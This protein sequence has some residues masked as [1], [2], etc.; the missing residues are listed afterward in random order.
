M[1]SAEAFSGIALL[2]L[3]ACGDPLP[4]EAQWLAGTW[5]WE[6]SCCTI[7][8]TGPVADA[9]NQF[10]MH[11]HHNGDVE[12]VE[13]GVQTQRTR[14]EVGIVVADTVL[15]FEEPVF[16]GTRYLVRRS[17]D[18]VTLFESPPRCNDCLTVH[19]FERA[20]ETYVGN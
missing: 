20:P 18:Q 5:Q 4:P 3:T 10:V 16:N 1:T 17:A 19:T 14:F 9:P 12:I 11:L 2:V 8:G 15:R 6:R 13:L 7:A